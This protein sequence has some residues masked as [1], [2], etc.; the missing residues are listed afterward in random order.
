MLLM[1]HRRHAEPL[2]QFTNFA[3]W[4][5]TRGSNPCQGTNPMSQFLNFSMREGRPWQPPGPGYNPYGPVAELHL[6]MRQVLAELGV[7]RSSGGLKAVLHIPAHA[8]DV[9]PETC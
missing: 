3:V 6:C 7:K 8:F 2:G 1:S 4:E 9:S 5:G